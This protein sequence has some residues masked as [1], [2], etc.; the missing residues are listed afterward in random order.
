[1][2]VFNPQAI[3]LVCT[4]VLS[5]WPSSLAVRLTFYYGTYLTAA[6]GYGF[7]TWVCLVLGKEPE[8]RSILIGLAV[9]LVCA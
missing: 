1:M 5:V 6:W 7:M 9:T 3:Q 4:I 8:G 2:P